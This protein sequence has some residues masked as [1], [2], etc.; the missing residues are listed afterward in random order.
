MLLTASHAASFLQVV[1]GPTRGARV[2]NPGAGGPLRHVT[3][4]VHGRGEKEQRR[5]RRRRLRSP[6]DSHG[7]R[8]HGYFRLVDMMNTEGV[9]S[10][11]TSEFW[12][13]DLGD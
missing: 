2:L 7:R 1:G 3:D 12:E 13:P 9:L 8:L 4:G 11:R 6:P 5:R 10:L